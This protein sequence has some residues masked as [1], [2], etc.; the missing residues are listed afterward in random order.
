MNSTYNYED[1]IKKLDWY[2]YYL[3][4]YNARNPQKNADINGEKHN[5][6]IS[7]KK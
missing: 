5:E 2:V 4:I 6:V 1:I 7:I 3:T